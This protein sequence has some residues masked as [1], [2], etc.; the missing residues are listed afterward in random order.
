[1]IQGSPMRILQWLLSLVVCGTSVWVLAPAAATQTPPNV[2]VILADDLGY[3]DLSSYG[4]RTLKTPALDRLAQEGIRFTSFYAAS[5]LCSPSRAA[6]L[7][8]RTPFRSGIQS[9][10]PPDEDIQLG[11]REITLATVLKRQGYQTFLS[12]KWHLNGGLDNTRH[13]QPSDHGFEQW[14]ALHAW[15]IP[16]HRN[17]TNFYRNGKPVGEIQGYAAAIVVDEALA[18][19]E[20][21]RREAPF[22]L[23][24]SFAEPHGTIASPDRFNAQY[25]AHTAGRPDPVPNAARVPDNLA[26]RGPGEYYAN[27]SHLDYQVGR[28][29][30]R[31]DRLGLRESTLVLFTSDNGPVTRDWRHWYEIN[32]YGS[33]GDLRGRKEDLYDGG[34]RVPAIVRWPGRLPAGRT[35]DEPVHSYDVMPTIAAI[36]GAP[37]PADRPIDG[38]NVSA[39]LRG[40][41]FRRARPLYWEF[42]DPNGF[43][44]ALRDGRWKLLADRALTRVR[45][46]DLSADRFEVVD[47]AGDEPEVVGR[48]LDELRRRRAEVETDPLRPRASG[49]SHEMPSR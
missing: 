14:L 36:V 7:T 47:R 13:L 38:E 11:R 15:A 22:F 2:V 24:L 12:G 46:F 45:L 26:A 42:D 1:M 5:P 28:L 33:A 30:E 48:L 20:R 23:Y 44:F 19:I 6:L 4:H 41:A 9:W 21:R 39:L 35:V 8:G 40:E 31:L 25:A 43:S 37:L 3:G 10:I 34:I 32:L 17:P 27:V 16:H 18:M 29:L 49:T